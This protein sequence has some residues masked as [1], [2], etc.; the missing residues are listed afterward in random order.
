MKDLKLGI[1]MGYWG[2]QPPEDII[3]IAKGKLRI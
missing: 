1:Q 3:G 2:A